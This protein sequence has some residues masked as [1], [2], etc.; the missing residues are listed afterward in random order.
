MECWFER[1]VVFET[2]EGLHLGFAVTI[3]GDRGPVIVTM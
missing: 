2:I 3:Y 1:I